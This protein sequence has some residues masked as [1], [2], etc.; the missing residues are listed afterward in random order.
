MTDDSRN[1]G[2]KYSLHASSPSK[3]ERMNRVKTIAGTAARRGK[4]DGANEIHAF[5][6]LC[7]RC[8][9]SETTRL[10]HAVA[11]FHLIARLGTR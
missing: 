7:H 8:E 6:T 2:K 9:I 11:P 4:K 1:G 3:R 5:R 10:L